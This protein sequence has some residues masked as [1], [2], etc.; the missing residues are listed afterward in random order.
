[1]TEPIDIEMLRSWIGTDES[2]ED[3]LTP[4]L[5]NRFHASLGLPGKAPELGEQA[6]GLIHFCL[7]HAV[8]PTDGLGQ[9]GHPRRGGFLPPVPLPRRMWAAGTLHFLGDLRVGDTLTRNSRIADVVVKDGRSGPLCFV[10]IDHSI[11]V[12]GTSVTAERQTIV[13]RAAET[14]KDTPAAE[15]PLAHAYGKATM[16]I[17]PNPALLF[18]YSALTFNSHRIHYDLDYARNEEG[19]RGLVVQGP[20]QATLLYHF[21]SRQCEQRQ[22]ELFE[23]RSVAPLFA[24]EEITLHCDRVDQGSMDLWTTDPSGGVS[25]RAKAR[26][27]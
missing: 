23:F 7:C 2:V 10:E 4:S 18:R 8:V 14:L 21:A 25:M 16:A 15:P 11:D 13:Y 6:P 27:L 20:L 5:V 19:Y 9:D 24:Q 22:P 1:M 17:M 12:R 26:W 3:I